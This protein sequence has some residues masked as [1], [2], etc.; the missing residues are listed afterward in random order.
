[1]P[2]RKAYDPT[3]PAMMQVIIIIKNKYKEDKK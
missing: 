3:D 1:M 2:A